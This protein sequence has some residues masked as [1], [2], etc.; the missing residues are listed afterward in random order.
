[1]TTN[2]EIQEVEY[3]DRHA[4]VAGGSG[5]DKFYRIFVFDSSWLVQYGRNGTVGTFGKIT[6]AAS[7]VA[8]SGAPLRRSC[9]PRRRRATSP[10]AAARS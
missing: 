2:V 1:M 7:P 5:S 3:V 4:G 10:A 9:A 8:S 6:V